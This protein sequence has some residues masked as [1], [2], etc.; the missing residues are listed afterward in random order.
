MW[1]A[2]SGSHL[3]KERLSGRKLIH[4]LLTFPLA[5]EFTDHLVSAA[6]SFIDDQDQWYPNT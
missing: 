6:D 2:D 1:V 5:V 4:S 3:D